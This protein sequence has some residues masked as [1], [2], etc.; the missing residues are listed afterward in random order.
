MATTIQD[1]A[2]AAGVSPMTVSNVLNGRSSVNDE[3]R[4][5][6]LKAINQLD[7]RV[8]VAARNL[9]AGRTGTIGLAVPEIDR[10]YAAQLA[11]RI[12]RVASARDI[13]VVVEETGASRGRELD[14]IARSRVRMYDGLIIASVGL[15]A[16]DLV[17]VLSTSPVVMLGERFSGSAVDHI[18]L[19][20]R[21][22]TRRAVEHLIAT[23]RRRIAIIGGPTDS[24]P[25][26]ANDV[27]GGY[28]LRLEGY[29]SAL[30]AAGISPDPTLIAVARDWDLEGGRRSVMELCDSAVQ[31]DA[32]I[33]MTDTLALGVLRGLADRSRSVPA[34]V[35]VV[36]FDNILESRY[37][38]PRLTTI[39]PDHDEIARLAVTLLMDRIAG[40][41]PPTETTDHTVGCELVIREST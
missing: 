36:G 5:R 33:G 19:P 31:F 11:A 39:A 9:R 26:T 27:P 28:E 7:Y 20:N 12:I 37:S 32:V 1:V 35:S 3:L 29:H 10:P 8:N 30:A 24:E 23:G 34:D 4:D 15:A 13:R 6:V 16:R 14:A 21:E 18:G 41:W 17:D 2:A 40:Q 22:G 25:G 38:I